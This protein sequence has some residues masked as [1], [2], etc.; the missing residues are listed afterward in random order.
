MG[1][2]APRPI[3]DALREVTD[4][5]APQTPLAAVQGVWA[6]AVGPAIAAEAMPVAVRDG[7]VIVACRSGTWAEQLD[8][9]QGELVSRLNGELP[10]GSRVRK[11]RLAA[12][13]SEALD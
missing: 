11:L 5:V 8:L 9:L 4:A 12:N 7:T 2:R 6:T 13:A 1:R 3:G 10:E